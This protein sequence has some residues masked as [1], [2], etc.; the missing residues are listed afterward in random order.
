MKNLFAPAFAMIVF[1][2]AYAMMTPPQ[3]A[4]AEKPLIKTVVNSESTGPGF[5]VRPQVSS[6]CKCGD[7]AALERR[8]ESL[9]SKLAAYGSARPVASNGS[10]GNGSAGNTATAKA[11]ASGLPYGSV[12]ISERVVS[13]SPVKQTTQARQPVRNAVRAAPQSCRIVNGVRICQ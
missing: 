8:V 2:L 3:T 9:E 4:Q 13:R 10:V 7:F 12:V 6:G 1:V 11:S 5:V